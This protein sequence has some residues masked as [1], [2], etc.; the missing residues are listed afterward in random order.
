MDTLNKIQRK[1]DLIINND[2]TLS[3]NYQ[4]EIENTAL[5]IE[6][7]EDYDLKLNGNGYS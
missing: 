2:I 4:N 5:M 6:E 7:E 3:T 1:A